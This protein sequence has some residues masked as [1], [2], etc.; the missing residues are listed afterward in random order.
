[1]HGCRR[2]PSKLVRGLWIAI[3]IM[4]LTALIMTNM[5]SFASLIFLAMTSIPLAYF[6]YWHP[7]SEVSHTPQ[8]Y[9]ISHLALWGFLPISVVMT[10]PSWFAG[11]QPDISSEVVFIFTTISYISGIPLMFSAM[12][13]YSNM[14]K[15]MAD[16]GE[17]DAIAWLLKTAPPSNSAEFF[18]KAGQM[19]VSKSI[20]SHYRP[21]LL[22]S[23]MPFLSLLITS[24][25]LPKHPSSES[26]T[27][28]PSSNDED[29]HSKRELENIEI[30]TACLA[31]L[32][33]FLDR[34]GSFKRLWEDTMQHPELEPP[35]V[36]KLVQ[37]ANL[38]PRHR[39]HDRL[40][41][42]AT[43]VLKNYKLDMEGKPVT[44][45]VPPTLDSERSR[46]VATVLRNAA[47]LMLN[48]SGLNNQKEPGHQ[49]LCEPV[50]L[51]LGTHVEPPHSSGDIEEA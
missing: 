2:L 37:F 39:L 33:D 32:S 1:M 18:K 25:H 31:R 22:K 16:T 30:Y 35:L 6:A 24:H 26:D 51:E 14:S 27:H 9:K 38:D 48:V 21:R 40:R 8:K 12:F 45:I 50:E 15:S 49:N 20:G 23:L 43:N 29:P 28:S 44:L 7:D 13:L 36:D 10:V 4:A 3:P 17:I 34:E 41:I 5:T 47:F 19:T 42:A 46:G 11:I